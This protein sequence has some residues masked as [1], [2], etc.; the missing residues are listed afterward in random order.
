MLKTIED[1]SST[2]KRL[3]IE[4]PS[5]ALEKEIGMSLQNLRGTLKIPGFR[6][7]K[8]P[9]NLI[10]KRFGKE[11][12]AEVMEKV[13]PQYYNNALRE[14]D[15][16]P[17]SLP[18]LDEEVNYTRNSP[19]NLSFTIEVMPKI[20]NLTYDSIKVE[21]IPVTVEDAD[22][23]DT[24]KKLQDK[25]A[26]FEPADKQ[27]EMDDLVSFDYVGSELVGEDNPEAQ[28]IISKMG[29]EIF[30]QDIMEKVVGKKKDDIIEY[31]TTF[32]PA[33]VQKELAGKTANIKLVIKEVKKKV[34]PA[35]DDEFAKE[36]GF[37]TFAALEEKLRANILAAKT[38][39]VRKIQK[40]GIVK[41]LIESHTFDVP[42][43]LLKREIESMV[44]EGK[45][46]EDESEAGDDQLS[47]ASAEG[48]APVGQE[49]F[50]PGKKKEE[51]DA[52]VKEKATMNVQGSIIVDLIGQKEGITVTDEELNERINLLAQKLSA[53]PEAVRSFYMY[54]EGSM[55]RLKQQIFEEKV[56]D[57]LLSR[58]SVEKAEK[59]ENA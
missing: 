30:P 27:V 14:A 44:I 34:L 59:E 33:I 19:L 55:D 56:L 50:D 15:L 21:D 38:E 9:V 31:T 35:L 46:P 1:L 52:R 53:T 17:V 51:L 22:M 25:K 37:D 49:A 48:D 20:D 26:L 42:E 47:A 16:K 24:L 10:E 45:M 41:Q 11:I 5:D 39:H 23:Q 58:A 8:A 43:S 32:D 40:A 6:Q 2:K 3:K 54:R 7:G 4:I 36:L 18:E 28:E 29:N 13:I 57:L 12:E